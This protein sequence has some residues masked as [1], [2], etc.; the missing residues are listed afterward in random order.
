M[1]SGALRERSLLMAYIPEEARWYLAE[2]VEEIKVEGTS[3][4]V[5]HNNLVL[6]H[7]QSPEEAYDKAIARGEEANMTYENTDG[8]AV[9]ITFRG[10]SELNVI[11]D[12]LEDGAEIAYEEMENLTEEEIQELLPSKG[13]LGVFQSV[14]S[15]TSVPNYIAKDVMD[16]V[17]RI[18]QNPRQ[19]H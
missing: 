18:I 5:V 3:S 11:M 6:I 14:E 19:D 9:T 2:I 8:Q 10:L 15:E 13:E 4:N 1:T 17:M 16:E 12:D 7:A